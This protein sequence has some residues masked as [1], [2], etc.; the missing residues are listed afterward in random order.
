MFFEKILDKKSVYCSDNLPDLKHCFTT[1]EVSAECLAGYFEFEP[2]NLIHP[3]QTHSSNVA[4]AEKGKDDYPETD[5]L[6]LTNYDQAVYLRFADCTPV[7]LY[8]KKANIAAVAHA[9]WKGTVASIVTKT[10]NAMLTYSKSDVTNIYAAIGPAIGVCCYKVGEEVEKGIKASV[11]NADNLIIEKE[12]G[13]YVDL[14]K[15]NA[16]QLIE[17][18]VPETNIDI[19]PFCTSCRNDLFYSYRKENGTDKRHYAIIKLTK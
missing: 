5:A 11:L 9:G 3:T 4:F 12:D 10:V 8:D 14:K 2:R 17:M 19:C 15:T 13:I 7:I 1:R 6:I 16:R 18:G